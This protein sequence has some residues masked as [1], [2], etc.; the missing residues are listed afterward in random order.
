M[1]TVTG[2]QSWYQGNCDGDWEHQFG[3]QIETLDNP[4]WLVKINLEGTLQEGV[5]FP[6]V[7]I[8]RS[9]QKP[10]DANRI[11][12]EAVKRSGRRCRLCSGVIVLGARCYSCTNVF[13][14]SSQT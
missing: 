14:L 3:I 12:W 13:L 11:L 5:D 1:N 2:L 9:E 7:K 4:G 10:G 8:D 6:A